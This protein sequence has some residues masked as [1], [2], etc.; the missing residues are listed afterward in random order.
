MNS[1][2][3]HASQSPPSET[4]HFIGLM[5]GTSLDGVD[6]VLMHHESPNATRMALVGHH[7]IAMPYGLRQELLALQTPQDNELHRGQIS[8]QALVECYVQAIAALLQ[9]TGIDPAQIAAIGAHG[10]TI[11][12]QPG[13]G[14]SIQLNAPHALAE[15]TGM[16][17]AVHGT[18]QGSAAGRVAAVLAELTS[19]REPFRRDIIR[20]LYH[21]M[22]ASAGTPSSERTRAIAWQKAYE[23]AIQPRYGSHLHS[24]SVHQVSGVPVVHP[25]YDQDAPK[26]NGS[27]V[28]NACFDAHFRRDPRLVAFGEDLGHLGDV[29]QGFAGLQAKYGE[30][31]ITDTGIREC[32]ILGQAIGLAMR[33]LRPIAE[34]QYLDYL[35]YA[36]QVMSDDL[37]TL[38]WRTKGGQKAP[39]IVRT[40]GHRLEGVWH[41][42]SP[43][44][45]ILNLVRGMYVCVPRN[46]TQAAGMYTTLLQSD[47]PGLIVEVLNGYRLKEPLPS[48][49]GEYTVPLGVPEVLRPGTDLTLVTYG[50]SCRVAMEAARD[51]AELGIDVEVI[52]VQTLLP[53]D[54][55][56]VVRASLQKTNRLMVLDEDV[57]G[58]ASAFILQQVLEHQDGYRWL[59]ARP[60]T[61]TAQ[62]HRPAYGTDGNFW[63]KPE[64]EHVFTAV[65]DI[66][67][68]ADPQRWPRL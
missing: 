66:M 56:G 35:L 30:L 29:N 18:L 40:R 58:G 54:T 13:H 34:I 24:H 27:E 45:G 3:S 62:E 44:A 41:S 51:A 15:A 39:V 23:D 20:A 57:P 48:N 12:H 55:Q 63:S 36:L 8:G 47:E 60:T 43:M 14:Y 33:G 38:Q 37:A 25:T 10:Q 46:M 32:T 61:V 65:Y 64:A 16:I 31:R 42:G 7:F 52:D 9:K 59:D 68:E 67:H 53:F 4:R 26:V 1:S 2:A 5:S 6:A 19:I 49:I 28:M 22:L 21:T 17:S 11:R 50:A